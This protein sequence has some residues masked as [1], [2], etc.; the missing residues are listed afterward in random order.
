MPTRNAPSA[1][2][3]TLRYMA[4]RLQRRFRGQVDVPDTAAFRSRVDAALAKLAA[5]VERCDWITL[6]GAE[7]DWKPAGVLLRAGERVTVLAQGRVYVSR[8]FDVG[9]GPQV[10]L[11]CRVGNAPVAKVV[12]NGSNIG[13]AAGGALQLA[14]KPSGE[15]ADELGNFDP[16]VP[17]DPLAGEFSIAVIRWRG[18]AGQALRAAAEQDAELFGPVLRRSEQPLTPAGWSP[19]WRL[20]ENEIYR[21]DGGALCCDT[22]A[23]AGILRF[24]ARRALTSASTLSWAWCVEQ[25]PSQLAE[26]IPPTHDYLSIAVEFDNGLDLTWMWSAALPVDTIFQCPLPWWDQRETHWVVRSGTQQLGQWLNEKRDLIADYRRAIGGELPNEIVAVWLIANT[27]FQRGV[28]KCQYRG[29]V[30]ADADG[31]VVVQA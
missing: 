1:L 31:R 13:S 21:Q 26:H 12:G 17:R 22:H 14:C 11:W 5:Q 8:G 27:A 4:S 9:F 3:T 28:G 15:F 24:P 23:N 6:S 7:A 18:E 16:A 25:L 19:L 20:G 2:P 10:G 29:I 30:L